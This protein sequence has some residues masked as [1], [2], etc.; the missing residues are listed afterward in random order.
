[1]RLIEYIQRH[2]TRCPEKTA[3]I[4]GASRITYTELLG[5]V[6]QFSSGLDTMGVARGARV[7]LV[8]NNSVEFVVVMLCAAYRD[9][10]IVPLCPTLPQAALSKAIQASDADSIIANHS[11]LQPFFE[12]A[13]ENMVF[14]PERC[15]AIG[16]RVPGC[17]L[18]DDVLTSSSESQITLT[19][20]NGNDPSFILTLTSG[21]TGAPKPIVLT[22][23]TKILRS[24]QAQDL[25]DITESDVILAATPLYHSLAERLVLLPLMTG[26]T[27]VVMTRFTP[28]NW[29]NSIVEHKVTFTIAVSS[30]LLSILKEIEERPV[31]MKSLRSVVSSSA[32][33]QHS[34][35]TRLIEALDCAFHECYGA[36]EIAIATNLSPS[37]AQMKLETV[38]RA[39]PGVD[40]RIMDDDH[41]EVP[42]GTV[43]EIACKSPLVFSGYYKNEV[44]TAASFEG[45][46]FLTGD[47]GSIDEDGYLR[48][49]GRKKEIIITGGINVYPVD[50]ENVLKHHPAVDDCA[51]IGVEDLT[52]GEAVLAIIE[53]TP[54]SDLQIKELR[55]YCVSRLADYQQ[56]MAYEV[57]RRLPT[58]AMGK[59]NKQ[60]LVE[61]YRGY[62]ATTSLRAILGR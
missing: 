23:R 37:D 30:Q 51:V 17:M 49:V 45:N 4:C 55:Q 54:G 59:I 20:A 58:N 34:I 36:S 15:V 6:M 2:A 10:T 5:Q 18:Y 32:L 28:Q 40:L 9:M 41:K 60:E 44:S 53:L 57:V 35:K 38:G 7:S 16:G 11:V 46:Y 12:N 27:S 13:N 61:A 43:G 31:E 47:M 62:D 24:L 22:Q 52:L 1:M 19:D 8:L 56:P 39:C 3:L 14:P 48:F 26:G 50:V 42:I 21:S 33:L 29:I 25:Y